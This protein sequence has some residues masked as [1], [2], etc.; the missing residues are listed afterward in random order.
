MADDWKL[1]MS[2]EWSPNLPIGSVFVFFE[3]DPNLAQ[4]FADWKSFRAVCD[5]LLD[6]NAAMTL[7][8]PVLK[9]TLNYTKAIYSMD[10]GEEGAQSGR[11]P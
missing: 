7:A 8:N 1:K 6:S 10:C 11:T 2:H 3:S 4:R 5:L 9:L